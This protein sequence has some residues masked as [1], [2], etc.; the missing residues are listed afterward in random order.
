M[1]DPSSLPASPARVHAYAGP[2]S[3]WG[4]GVGAVIVGEF[5]GWNHGLEAGGFGGLLVATLIVTVLYL[6][7]AAS[8]AELGTAMP[9][10]GGAYAYARAALGPW[11]GYI[12]GLAQ[13]IAYA[14]TSAVAVV[15]L[16]T[17]LGNR[18]HD[19]AGLDLPRPFW[20]LGLYGLIVSLN[21]RGSALFF[22][23]AVILASL[24]LAVLAAFWALAAG[25]FDASLLLDST[26]R[27]A[28][29]P[30]LPNGTIG[31]AWAIPFAIWFYLAIEEVP[32][33][34]EETRDPGRDL[35]RGLFW[36]LGTLIVATL[37]TLFLNSGVA[38]GAKA[39]ARS[40]EPLLHALSELIGAGPLTDW[41]PL[42]IGVGALSTAHST[43]YAAGR[44]IF[45]LRSEE[46]R[47]GKECRRLCRSRWSPYH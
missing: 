2:W 42:L 31:V 46:R 33:A 22:R 20:W 36:G 19:V 35:P 47:V 6:C 44:G 39:V 43:L 27:P 24:A 3:L 10:A 4:L 16:G 18:L 26:P 25:V 29:T 34:A 32:L 21:A 37:L 9:F 23:V 17:V 5:G 40:D 11:A 14:L 7:L 28:G 15:A 12:A 38:P 13:T 41:L 45:A 30:W 1:P 8:L